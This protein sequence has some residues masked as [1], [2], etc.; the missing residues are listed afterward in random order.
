MR[1]AALLRRVPSRPLSSAPCAATICAMT[2]EHDVLGHRIRLITPEQPLYTANAEELDALVC[3]EG[4]FPVPHRRLVYS[5]EGGERVVTGAVL[6]LR[7]F[8]AHFCGIH[9]YTQ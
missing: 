7:G 9:M 1:G 5:R 8:L 4:C 3:G 2:A 6:L